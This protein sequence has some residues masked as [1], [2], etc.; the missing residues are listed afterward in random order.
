MS[1]IQLNS[2]LFKLNGVL[3]NV[4]QEDVY[5]HV[6]QSVVLRAFEG[7]NGMSYKSM[8]L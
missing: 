5:D 7:Y 2:W 1:N 3:H 8:Q 4:S 6:A